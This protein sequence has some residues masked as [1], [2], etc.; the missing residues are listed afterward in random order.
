M[1]EQRVPVQYFLFGLS[2]AGKDTVAQIMNQLLNI[3]DVALADPIRL[4]Y[5]RFVG[6][7]DGKHDRT[8]MIQIGETYKRLYGQDVWCE[9]ATRLIHQIEQRRGAMRSGTV[10]NKAFATSMHEALGF[11]NE[12]YVITDGRYLHEYDY[13]VGQRGFWPIRLVADDDVRLERLRRRDGD[14]QP[15]ALAWEREHFIGS[16]GYTIYNNTSISDLVAQISEMHSYYASQ[17]TEISEGSN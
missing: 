9:A 12:G 2:G 13:F 4:E 11:L 7:P 10:A 3:Y 17:K 5:E 8:K 1:T 6:L 16:P 15:D 14:T